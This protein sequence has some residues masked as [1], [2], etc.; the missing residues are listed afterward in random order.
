MTEALKMFSVVSVCICV[1]PSIRERENGCIAPA[2]NIN[3]TTFDIPLN[4]RI[5]TDRRHYILHEGTQ[6]Q[7][8]LGGIILSE[9]C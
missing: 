2:S 3:L 7:A 8:L 5:H 4:T 6:L 1:E 9:S